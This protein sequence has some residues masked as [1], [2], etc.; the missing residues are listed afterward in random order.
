MSMS[1]Q[2]SE[3]ASLTKLSKCDPLTF[4]SASDFLYNQ[5][6]CNTGKILKTSDT[7]E[8][9]VAII[10]GHY[11]GNNHIA[12]QMQ[13]ILNQS[14]QS[15]HIF[16]VD[17]QSPTP[18]STDALCGKAEQLSKISVSIR[19]K[20]IGF[21]NNFI[22][23]LADIDQPFEYFAFS[24]QD[25]I[26]HLDK[27]ERAMAALKKTPPG[28]AALYCSRTEIFDEKCEHTLGYSPLFS[29]PPSF[30]NALVQNIGGGNTM[31]F[32]RAARDLIITATVE[33]NIVSHDWWCYQIVTGAGGHIVYDPKPS[34]KYRQHKKNLVGANSNWMARFTRIRGLLR[35]QLSKWNDIN[36]K[37][38]K[39]NE[40]LLTTK[41]KKIL[42]D[43][44]K[45]R[46]SFLL[47][48]LML[49]KRS[50]IYR[51]TTFGNLGLL[52]GIILKKV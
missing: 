16:F 32:N 2:E 13:S 34:L 47:K 44:I 23:A 15:Y 11:E 36:T 12:E 21:T 7:Y 9:K 50:G 26:W 31:V 10:L 51:Q 46:E 37:I 8:N 48:R 20:N 17:D 49:F 35:G 43:F 45:A 3:R 52:L 1:Y 29:R 39:E 24:D 33:T 40:H 6:T 28:K 14:Y 18:I 5:D 41:N 19:P 22:G 42:N 4:C 38:L 25:D 27:L 30:A